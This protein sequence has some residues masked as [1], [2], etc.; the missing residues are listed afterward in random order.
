MKNFFQKGYNK[1]SELVRKYEVKLLNVLI[2]D[3]KK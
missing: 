1:S 3:E 2:R